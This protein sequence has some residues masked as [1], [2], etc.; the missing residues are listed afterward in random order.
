[1]RNHLVPLSTLLGGMLLALFM[2]GTVAAYSGETA[3]T[4]EVSA[5][6][7]SLACDTPLT[8]TARVVDKDGKAID[9]QPV[10]WSF[11]PDPGSVTGDTILDTATTTNA[12]GIATTQVRFACTPHDVKI[13]A[14][15]DL[16]TG[17]V[18][19]TVS[20]VGLPGTG[21]GLPRT[22]TTPASSFPTMALSGLAV[23]IGSLTI[24]RR[25]AADRR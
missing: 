9:E 6:S 24:L 14:A 3:K 21:Q 12:G 25:F 22:D 10:G 16:A 4:V 13:V 17:T 19:V 5:P 23:L 7:G 15:A 1:M 11:D 20:G 2:A 18:A 8:F